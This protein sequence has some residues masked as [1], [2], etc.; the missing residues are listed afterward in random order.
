MK[1]SL[2]VLALAGLALGAN[3]AVA[4]WSDLSIDPYWQNVR[5]VTF[6]AADAQTAPA[7][8]YDQVDRYNP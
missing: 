1:R 8:K 3:V 6:V 5:E 4:D 2:T 7:G